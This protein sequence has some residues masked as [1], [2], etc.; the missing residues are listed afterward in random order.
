MAIL[1][2]YFRQGF[3]LD[4]G[5]VLYPSDGGRFDSIRWQR[6]RLSSFYPYSD[7]GKEGYVF[8]F[9]EKVSCATLLAS[10][11]PNDSAENRR[12]EAARDST[13]DS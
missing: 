2:G 12:L 10:G 11:R 5:L 3:L 7:E 9:E 13:V 1:D 6:V 8:D 4:R